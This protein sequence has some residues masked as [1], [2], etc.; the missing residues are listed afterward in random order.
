M[1]KRIT[2]LFENPWLLLVIRLMNGGIFFLFAFGKALQPHALFY[3]DVKNYM[4]LPEQVIPMLGSSL[5]YIELL[6]GVLLLLGV[7]TRWAAAAGVAMLLMFI[8]FILQAL[9]RGI[10]LTNCGC[11]GGIISLGDTP[12][13]VL[14]RDMLMLGSLAWLFAARAHSALRL[15]QLF[16]DGR[17][18]EI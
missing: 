1:K 4:L 3:E 17:G 9:A 18:R 15:D 10:V 7:F 8:V 11:S 16:E 5:I 2:A 12:P 13:E 14:I 6:V